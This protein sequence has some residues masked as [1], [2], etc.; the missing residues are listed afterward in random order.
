MRMAK[1][2]IEKG[3]ISTT[4]LMLLLFI[5]VNSSAVLLAPSITGKYADENLWLS[6]ALGSISGLVV[7]LTAMGLDRYF[8]RKTVVEY[9]EKLLGSIVG[10]II[11]L[12]F[13]FFLLHVEGLIMRQYMEFVSGLFLDRTPMFV[14]MGGMALLVSFTARG[15]IEVVGRVAQLIVPATLFMW[16]ILLLFTI[17]NWD[18]SNLYP[19]TQ[20]GF[21]GALRGSVVP[22]SWFSE[23]FLVTFLLPFLKSNGRKRIGLWGILVVL[24]TVVNLCAV[25]LI[26]VLV[27]GHLVPTLTYPVMTLI[28]FINIADFFQHIDALLL[29]IWVSGVFIKLAFFQYC[30]SLGTAQLFRLSDYRPI[31][32]PIG[33]LSVL[34][35]VWIAPNI[36]SLSQFLKTTGYFYLITFFT[37]YPLLLLAIA[38][39]RRKLG[40]EVS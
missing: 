1:S 3:R 18:F 9:G 36:T 38:F 16:T 15:G 13:L 19:L 39:V 12:M 27:F 6:P 14:I 20:K 23:L 7:I 11:G 30:L 40:N 34:F 2:Q 5:M 8:P 28:R 10:K 22:E 26:T 37:V 4:Q 31:S 25:N 21:M 24:F 17:P 33:F 35:G 29:V 32:L